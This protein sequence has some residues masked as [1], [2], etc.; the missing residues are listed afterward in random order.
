MLTAGAA[1]TYVG[2]GPTRLPLRPRAPATPLEIV[3]GQKKRPVLRSPE[4]TAPSS[5]MQSLLNRSMRPV[6][7]SMMWVTRPRTCIT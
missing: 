2:I 4:Q 6:C 7:S 1:S 3:R 5:S